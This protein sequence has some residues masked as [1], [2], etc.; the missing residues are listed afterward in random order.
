MNNPSSEA[1]FVDGG[2]LRATTPSYV[3]RPADDELFDALMDGEYCYI[4]TPRQMGKSSLMIRT[5][6]R[7]KD[8]NIQSAVVDIQGIGT[9]KVREWYASLLSRIR[10][11][12]RLSVDIDEWMTKKSNVGFGQ[13]FSDFIQDVVLAEITD[14]VVIFL[15]EVDWM[16]KIDFRDDFF[17]SI[18]SM[19]N[20]RAQYPEFNRISFVLLGVA[21][22][23]DLISEPTRTPF[24]IGHAIPLQE[25]SLADATPLQDGLEQVCPGE[26]K[27][28]L[29][30]IFYWTNGHPYL[31]QKICKTIFEAGK[32]NWSDT[33]V[34]E[35]VHRLF[36]AEE[37]RKEANL[38]FI[39]DRILSN[40][41]FAQLLKLYKRVR[42][43]KIKESGQSIIQNQLML[44]GL[45]TSRDGYLEVRNQIYRTVFNERWIIRYMPKNWQ[46]VALVS[47]SSFLVF[48]LA[49]LGYNYT[50]S[51]RLKTYQ[52][53]YLNADSNAEKIS[54]LASIYRLRYL[55]LSNTEVNLTATESFYD[56]SPDSRSQLMLFPSYGV[57][58]PVVQ[59]DLVLV[60]SE[61]YITVANVDLESDNTGLLKAMHEALNN[62]PD[63]EIAKSIKPEIRA[64]LDGRRYVFEGDDTFALDAYSEAI[65]LNP[66]NQATLYERAKV[67]IALG[68][69]ENAL[70]DLDA[71]IGAARQSA[72]DIPSTSTPTNSPPPLSETPII[73]ETQPSTTLRTSNA[74][75]T[76]SLGITET[77]AVTAAV[78]FTPTSSPTQ[79]TATLAPDPELAPLSSPE[80]FESN[81]I[82]LNHVIFAVRVLVERT[83]EL[84][85][86]LQSASAG[87]VYTNLEKIGLVQWYSISL[88][89]VT[90]P[91]SGLLAAIL[92]RGYILVATDSNYEPQS[93][94]NPAG[95]RPTDTQCP[96]SALTSEEMRGFDVD[97]AIEVGNRIGVETCFI[98]PSW[99]TVIAGGWKDQWDISIGSMAITISLQQFLDFS[100]PYYYDL[101]T[102]VTRSDSD[103][104]SLAELDGQTLCVEASTIYESWLN[105][106]DL[107]LP[108]SS[109]VV[110]PPNVKIV[111]LP[112]EQSCVEGITARTEEFVGYVTSEK[113]L[114][115]D[116]LNGVPVTAIEPSVF[117]REAAV[118]FD[119]SATFSTNSLLTQVNN[120]LGSMHSDG[121]LSELSIRWFGIDLTRAPNISSTP[122]FTLAP[123]STVQHQVEG[124]EWLAQIARCYGADLNAV[125]S[126][127]PQINDA[128]ANLL[129]GTI[130]VPNIGSNGTIY[131]PPCVL[132]YTVQSGDTW[133]SIAQKFN[134]DVLL[135]QAANQ[136]VALSNGVSLRI[137][138]TGQSISTPNPSPTGTPSVEDRLLA[139]YTLNG[140]IEDSTG[141]Y[142]RID[143]GEGIFSGDGIYCDGVAYSC[144]HT[145]PILE[146]NYQNFSISADFKIEDF[147][148]YQM[149][150]FVGGELYRWIGFNLNTDGTVGLLYNNLGGLEC[151]GKYSLNT[152]HN[153]LITY[154]GSIGRLY[155]D[156]QLICSAEFTIDTQGGNTYKDV[157]SSN[158]SNAAAF[159]GF[160]R[161]L[162]IYTMVIAP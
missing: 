76:S 47:I 4:L 61:L 7:L 34:D 85:T 43:G 13:L 106:Q 152:W 131:G 10:R 62:A 74:T 18:R 65:N 122:E 60:I 8:E 144:I 140:T 35:L 112:A 49:V 59:E 67:Y 77:P 103:I 110:N 40:E 63:N 56:F 113:A 44:S 97:V 39:Q 87:N 33:E 128:N 160:I 24:N 94:L 75:E 157:S 15:D 156:S 102:V 149:P 158:Y 5:S 14:P 104:T 6:Q 145:S 159:K 72:P 30:R 20:A 52:S 37:S 45:L 151:Q 154:D 95:I 25:L 146:L 99:D 46:R 90:T 84:Q 91:P 1:Y 2:T 132:Y 142:P 137:P 83:P 68:Q 114:F 107:D 130:T 57:D 54:A 16:I 81:F 125:Q 22:P 115:P 120:I 127:N 12:L 139:Y 92:E 3:K 108:E 66:N 86:E 50:V 31:T 69:Y 55:F 101:A 11:G 64:W 32:Q 79:P 116:L 147:P 118:A 153:A 71:T 29:E 41:Q 121:T 161:N 134:A 119:K 136:G 27:R 38:K 124:G 51:L 53:D 105:N 80:K 129:P 58:D 78:T 26:G 48:L 93:F 109:N 126:A 111:S 141:N 155:L 88:E 89:Q 23:A 123:G 36:L 138:A 21:S 133:S 150:V 98:T 143:I 162:K 82:T 73:L 28:I 9:N 70:K 19:Y 100:H 96:A 148:Q 117:T 135:L 17:A 42:R